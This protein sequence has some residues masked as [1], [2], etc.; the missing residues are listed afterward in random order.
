MGLALL[1]W[2]AFAA[3][4]E[5]KRV[6]LVIGNSD[7]QNAPKLDNAAFDAR[8]VADAFRRLGFK[9]VDGYDLSIAAMRAKVSEFSA[10]LPGA[11]SAVIYY[12]GH[13][14]SVD[15][16][17]YLIPTDIM[18]KSPTDLDL[19]AISVSLLLRQMKRE[20][21]VNVVVLDA[22]RGNPFAA[23]LARNKTRAIIA[24]RGLSRIDDDLARGTLIAFASDPKST[25]LD[26]PPGQHS[27]FTEA[28]LNHVFDAGASIDTVMSRVR[29]EV[30]EKTHHNQLPWVN[31]S[32]IGDY[33][34]NRGICIG[35]AAECPTLQEPARDGAA[36]AEV[37]ALPAVAPPDRQTLED[38]LW[39]SAQHSNL[40]ADYQAYLD[41]F[42]NGVFAQMAKNRIASLEELG[43]ARSGTDWKSE[44]GTA[45]TEKEL[46]LT[47]A[48]QK[49]IQQRLTAL[50][51]Y[52][53]PATG[54]FNPPTRSAITEWQKSRGVALSSFL[55]PMQLAE[56]REE[57]E[58]AYQTLLAAQSAPKPAHAQ[59]VKHPAKPVTRAAK[60]SVREPPRSVFGPALDWIMGKGSKGKRS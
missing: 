24:E 48:E 45:E 1:I 28:F 50:D 15:E 46:N 7:Y 26:G 12:A 22:C 6:A 36:G 47:P 25:A 39:E 27:P 58:D 51:L 2:P 5:D 16:E 29:T 14:I 33:T 35:T 55:G 38:L 19:G 57:S 34:L 32:L 13:G 10:D 9:V 37:A 52:K 43:V 49:E 31:T 30:W 17:N 11:K 8:A 60:A 4:P 23:D 40:R 56:L 42:P 41:A 59:A 3:A 20:D 53:G 18:L 21:H 44:I 54:A